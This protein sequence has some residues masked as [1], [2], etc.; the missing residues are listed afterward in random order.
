M[1]LD[2]ELR[3]IGSDHD[4]FASARKQS[5][6]T[7][8]AWDTATGCLGKDVATDSARNAARIAALNALEVAV[9]QHN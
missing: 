4:Q 9:A 1:H 3:C 6:L 7:R 5:D 8:F 2:E